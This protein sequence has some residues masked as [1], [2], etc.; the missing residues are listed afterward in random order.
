MWPLRFRQIKI[1]NKE[2]SSD[3]LQMYVKNILA[4]KGSHCLKQDLCILRGDSWEQC[5]CLETM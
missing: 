3:Y 4:E 5:D 1:Y 2:F